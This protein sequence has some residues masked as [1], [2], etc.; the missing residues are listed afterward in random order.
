MPATV[1][2]A[3]GGIG[4][5]VAARRLRR[6]L[7]KRHR[8]V[9]VDR[10]PDFVFAPSLLWV[11]TGARSPEAIRASRVWTAGAS[12]SSRRRDR[13]SVPSDPHSS[14]ARLTGLDPATSASIK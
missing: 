8:V 4:G 6:L 10:E 2:V 5:L 7:P 1:V 9:L 3:G 11:T 12:L 14:V 13:A